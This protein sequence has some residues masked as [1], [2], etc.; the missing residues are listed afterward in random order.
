MIW[1]YLLLFAS[2]TG[3]IAMCVYVLR[4]DHFK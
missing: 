2:I 3:A 1:L 4:E